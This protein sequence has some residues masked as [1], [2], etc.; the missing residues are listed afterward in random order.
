MASAAA[1]A[2]DQARSPLN[3]EISQSNGVTSA[4]VPK[5]RETPDRVEDVEEDEV[6]D[7]TARKR[8][9]GIL[10]GDHD[11]GYDSRQEAIRGAANG[12]GDD[13]FGDE[14]EEDGLPDDPLQQPA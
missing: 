5:D 14:E 6:D 10:G 3:D 7:V 9:A 13:L 8:R 11:N 12:A 4:I 1:V 2:V